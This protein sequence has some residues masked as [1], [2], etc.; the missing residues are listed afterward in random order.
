MK[1]QNYQ[2]NFDFF[3]TQ[4]EE[5]INIPKGTILYVSELITP[6]PKSLLSY[7]AV[8]YRIKE[9]VVIPASFIEKN[10]KFF[11]EISRNEIDEYL[12]FLCA[13]DL[14]QSSKMDKNVMVEEL[15]KALGFFAMTE[16]E[17]DKIWDPVD[18]DI[19]LEDDEYI[20]GKSPV[21]RF[22]WSSTGPHTKI[23]YND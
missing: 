19:D 22:T 4:N 5:I 1:I 21:T 14:L 11:N 6:N 13:I 7:V 18:E 9:K 17:I 10:E 3:Y 20:I 8:H 15:S 12:H 23:E 2:T 16:S